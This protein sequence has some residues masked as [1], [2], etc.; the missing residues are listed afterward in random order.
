[1]LHIV[2][3]PFSSEFTSGVATGGASLSGCEERWC[4]GGGRGVTAAVEIGS[5]EVTG[6]RVRK[7]NSG[8]LALF[9]MSITNGVPSQ[10]RLR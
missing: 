3:L 2:V 8:A 4:D 7:G 1:M 9:V 10:K 5:V 6:E